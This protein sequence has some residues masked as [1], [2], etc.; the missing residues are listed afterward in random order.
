MRREI[1]LEPEAVAELEFSLLARIDVEA[2][3]VRGRFITNT[4]SQPSVY[5]Q[6]EQEAEAFMA[7]QE[8]NPALIPNLVREA[9]RTGETVYQVAWVILSMAHEWSQISAAIEDLRLGAKDQVRAAQ[10][11]AGKR[12]AANIDWTPILNLEQN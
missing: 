9:T 3:Q 10:T 6:K 11:V 12:Q 8:I 5:L 7:N 1:K 4:A 2:E